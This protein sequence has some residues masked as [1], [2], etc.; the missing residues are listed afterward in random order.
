MTRPQVARILSIALL[1]VSAVAAMPVPA[2]RAAASIASISS[3]AALPERLTDRE[4][5]QLTEQFSE[6]GGTFH[7]E[8][9]I[10]NENAFQTVVPD[11]IARATPG[12]LYLG[13][14]PEQNF[15]YMAAIKPRMAFIVDIRR[16]NLQEHLL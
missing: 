7:S 6:P 13:V 8:N 15:T 9:Y 5:W 14:G 10:S 12:R 2:G 16:G 1:V 3:I 4:F 11:L